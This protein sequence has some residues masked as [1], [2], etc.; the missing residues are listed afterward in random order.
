MII[1]RYIR[2]I[3]NIHRSIFFITAGIINLDLIC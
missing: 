3:V 2:D 1:I